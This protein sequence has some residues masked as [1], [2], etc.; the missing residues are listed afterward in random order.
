LFARVG[1]KFEV[2]NVGLVF[3]FQTEH[4]VPKRHSIALFTSGGAYHPSVRSL[5]RGDSNFMSRSSNRSKKLHC[6]W[7]RYNSEVS[8]FTLMRQPCRVISTVHF[9]LLLFRFRNSNRIEKKEFR[10][11][12]WKGS[13]TSSVPNDSRSPPSRWRHTTTRK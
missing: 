11:N 1:S 10:I 5:K 12:P 4:Q 7:L 2:D 9:S 8:T 6:T 13:P 3:L